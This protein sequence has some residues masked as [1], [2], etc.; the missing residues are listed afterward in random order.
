[1]K[2]AFVMQDTGKIWGAEKATLDLLRGLKRAGLDAS[3]ILICEERLGLDGSLLQAALASESICMTRI[4]TR[5]PFSPA[6]IRDLRKAV[7]V[8]NADIVHTVGPKATVHA[9]IAFLGSKVKRV[10]TVHGWLLRPDPKERFYEWIEKQALRRFDRVIVL[11]TFYR[12]LLEGEGF[13]VGQVALIPAGV[14]P[15][16]LVNREEAL[17]SLGAIPV[18]TIGM[19]SRLSEEKNHVMFI[20]AARLLVDDGARARF[21]IAG[22]G[23][24]KTVIQ[25]MIK[26]NGLAEH[27]ELMGYV[28][29]SLFMR[30]IHCLA[31]CSRIEN[32]PQNIKEAMGWCR[33]VIA[34]RVGGIS[35]LVKE[36][37]TGFLVGENNANRMADCVKQMIHDRQAVSRLGLS[38]R[39]FIESELTLEQTVLGHK[40]LYGELAG[41]NRHAHY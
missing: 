2:I 18:F 35:D 10:S 9:L 15:A 16:G 26:D 1:M 27:M 29:A 7:A 31:V 41:S 38:A 14:D 34:T 5:R 12:D 6:L 11:S 13:R 30:K 19:L 23:R 40:R 28:D 24:L 3:V 21:L 33:P 25:R 4:T 20:R 8:L 36:G 32:L 37:V 39:L 17:A 22:E